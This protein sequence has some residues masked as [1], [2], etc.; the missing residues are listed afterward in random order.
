MQLLTSLPATPDAIAKH[1]PMNHN[2]G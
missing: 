1:T 2:A